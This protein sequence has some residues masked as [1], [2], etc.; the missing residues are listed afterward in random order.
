MARGVVAVAAAAHS[1]AAVAEA[2]AKRDNLIC[3]AAWGELLRPRRAS[4]LLKR[5]SRLR[6]RALEWG[7]SS[8][9][10]DGAVLKQGR[11]P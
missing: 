1:M 11:G 5:R 8:S 4:K 10:V 9:R 7:L 2:C 6:R 3:G